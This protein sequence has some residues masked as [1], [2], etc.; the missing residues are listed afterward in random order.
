MVIIE[1]PH[2][3]R[4]GAGQQPPLVARRGEEL[5]DLRVGA[6]VAAQADLLLLYLV[7]SSCAIVCFCVV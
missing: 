3:L 4:R 6:V 2:E 7:W 1:P 5:Q